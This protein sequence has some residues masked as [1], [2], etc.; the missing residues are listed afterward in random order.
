MKILDTYYQILEIYDN[1]NFNLEKWNRYINTIYEN[2]AS[3]F[4]NDMNDCIETGKYTF[5][6]NYL[7]ILNAVYKEVE[8]R[9]QAHNSFVKAMNGLAEKIF[10]EFGREL[11]VDIVFY[12]GL[13]NAAGWVKNVNGRTVIFLGLEKIMELNWCDLRSMYGLLYHEL[14]HVYQKQY[15]VLERSFDNNRESFLWELFT[16]GIA[17]YFEQVLVGDFTFFHQDRNGWKSWCDNHLDEIKSD[18]DSDLQTMS[19]QNQ[20][21]FGDWVTYQGHGDV[22]YYLGCEWIHF[23]R[24]RYELEEIINWDMN[25]VEKSYREFVDAGK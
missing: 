8:L 9:E 24:E 14:G 16:E 20:K 15:G 18:F 1:G 5:V 13:C 22:G 12:L 25:E 21:Y 6:D 11:D 7:P 10:S 2:S 3:L 17:M 23:I 4:M 19:R